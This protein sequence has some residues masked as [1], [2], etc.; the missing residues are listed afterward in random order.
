MRKETTMKQFWSTLVGKIV[1]GTAGV[2]VVAAIVVAVVFIIKPDSYRSIKVDG[3][4]GNVIVESTDKATNNAYKGMTLKSQDSVSVEIDSN[5]TLLLDMDKYMFANEGTKFCIEATGNQEKENT[6]TKIVMKE[7]SVLYRLDS[8]LGEK[9][10]F[11]I[12][13]PNSSM[14]V[15]GTIFRVTVYTDET[16]KTYT[17][18]DVL[19]GTVKVDAYMEDGKKASDEGLIEAGKSVIVHREKDY[20]EFVEGIEEIDYDTFTKAMAQFVVDS[21]EE[22]E[23]ICV[24]E[25]VFKHLTDLEQHP[26]IEKVVEEAT[27]AKEGKKE[28][29][30]E[31]CDMV[32][33]T[34]A[35]E[36]L[37]HTEGEWTLQS[38]STC[39]DKDIEALLCAE[40]GGV[41]KTRELELG[42]HTYGGWMVLVVQSILVEFVV[43]LV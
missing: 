27:C 7:G 11:T 35:I 20:S 16:G 19:D 13:T 8:K 9:E 21:I 42:E 1:A 32:M 25:T 33:R 15:R 36:K 41:I 5:M 22:G 23:E 31:T 34:E 18:V 3:V 39:K 6:K 4:N 30:C 38:E 43:P 10:S 26:E 37:P 17:V 2:C 40:C 12:D 28:F 29:Y 14:S 24:G